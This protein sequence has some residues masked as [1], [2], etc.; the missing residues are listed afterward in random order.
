MLLGRVKYI[1]FNR[2]QIICT[3]AGS[4]IAIPSLC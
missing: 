3:K 2:L 4:Q 1:K